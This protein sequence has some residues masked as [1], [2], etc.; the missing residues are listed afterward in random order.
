MCEA[1]HRGL[2]TSTILTKSGSEPRW[3]HAC[4][5][6]LA[7]AWPRRVDEPLCVRAWGW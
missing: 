5:G 3:R 6:R 4:C 1:A 7:A 2:P